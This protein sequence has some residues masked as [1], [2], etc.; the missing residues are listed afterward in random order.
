[1]VE[2]VAG[3]ERILDKTPKLRW[4]WDYVI[5][6]TPFLY[7]SVDPEVA[8]RSVRSFLN[9]LPQQ[10]YLLMVVN[11]PV[12]L[13]LQRTNS[14][15]RNHLIELAERELNRKISWRKLRFYL[16]FNHKYQSVYNLLSSTFKDVE[17]GKSELF[18]QLAYLFGGEEMEPFF[19]PLKWEDTG[20]RILGKRGNSL[21]EVL[22]EGKAPNEVMS[23]GLANV[24]LTL[25]LDFFFAM[26]FRKPS[27]FEYQT[28]LENL[29]NSYAKKESV[30]AGEVVGE[31]AQ[32]LADVLNEKESLWY[33]S[34]LLVLFGSSRH[35]LDSLA[36]TVQKEAKKV[37]SF[38]YRESSGLT[39]VV[40][41]FENSRSYFSGMKLERKM[42]ESSFAI[43]FPL[44][45]HGTGRKDGSGAVYRNPSGEPVF[46]SQHSPTG[47]G[48]V[49]G[50]TGAGKS[51]DIT[52]SSL[53][54]DATVF[55]EYIE[56]DTGSY[57]PF[58]EVV[59]GIEGYIPISIDRPL[60]VNP[61]G[62][63]GLKV[64]A[65]SFLKEVGIDY[66][67]LDEPD[68]AVL[69]EV[70][71]QF[72]DGRIERAKLLLALE[73]S[74][75][76]YL[77]HLLGETLFDTVEVP[78]EIDRVKLSFATSVVST[79]VAGEEGR[80]SAEE[81]AV[82]SKVVSEVYSNHTGDREIVLSDF[83]DRLK[84]SDDPVERS[85]AKKL[86]KFTKEGEYGHFF[87]Y[88]S[89][90]SKETKNLYIELRT[91][92]KELLN[93]VMLSLMQFVLELYS[94]PK[95]AGWRRRVVIDEGWS[96]FKNE[97]LTDFLD[98]ALRT[99][100]KK[101]IAITFT[102]QSPKDFSP[103]LVS[104]TTV[105]IFKFLTETEN[106]K[107]GFTDLTQDDIDDIKL[108]RKPEDLNYVC[109]EVYIQSP[110]SLIGRAHSYLYLPDFYYWL[111]TTK[112]EDKLIRYKTVAKTGDIL[113]AIK[114]LGG[115][116]G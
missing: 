113:S 37:G 107:E 101:G 55:I 23:F 53:F 43:Y 19:Y 83:Y 57:K 24:F 68:I 34:S 4:N 29:L 17:D 67:R 70:L 46:V 90:L 111:S 5:G 56:R 81:K 21:A 26:R 95:L 97:Y 102:S 58:L 41:L 44:L 79:M 25:D 87:D 92:S 82:V 116:S 1:M 18:S 74:G 12:E 88:P 89:D 105:R 2:T 45:K 16:C 50:S 108:L 32:T 15:K 66:R 86:F 76:E 59:E 8:E 98:S 42:V 10:D 52:W 99:F 36:E 11:T 65:V 64:S 31:F 91:L 72:P 62:R 61:F 20:F 13:K 14:E 33:Y 9:S 114:E 40:K 27:I 71:S 103:T 115:I 63:S 38:L 35:Q 96:V 84:D 110:L 60:S 48:T 7:N 93:P 3:Y 73:E 78:P 85:V 94:D 77:V 80:I 47:H 75:A 109:S 112:P 28:R 39:Q 100:R 106:L 49:I 104:Q 51:V 6:F 30:S 54:D 69:E 22:Y